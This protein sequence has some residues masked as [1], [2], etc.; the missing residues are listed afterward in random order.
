MDTT[1]TARER[2]RNIIRSQRVGRGVEGLEFLRAQRGF[3]A[4]VGCTFNGSHGARFQASGVRKRVG[5]EA[6]HSHCFSR[7]NSVYRMC[8]RTDTLP[9]I[10]RQDNR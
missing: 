9:D 1:Q 2:S 5:R 8:P 3:E 4:R 7:R 6:S 10:L